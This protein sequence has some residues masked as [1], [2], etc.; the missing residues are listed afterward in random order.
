MKFT[1]Q[2][3]QAIFIPPFSFLDGWSLLMPQ[4]FLDIN[5]IFQIRSDFL[6]LFFSKIMWA[7]TNFFHS[8]LSLSCR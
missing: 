6:Q 8:E 4:P 5:L 3:T 7:D 1:P 2:F